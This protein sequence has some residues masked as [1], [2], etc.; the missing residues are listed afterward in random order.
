M[1]LNGKAKL[2]RIFVGESD[3]VKHTPLYEMIVKEAHA[4]GL[5]GA[6]AWRGMLSYGHT[7]HIHTAK[8]LDLSSNLPIVIEIIDVAT[9]IDGFIPRL[10]SLFEEAQSDGLVTAENVAIVKY[11]Q[12]AR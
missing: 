7:S 10:D 6:T 2:L 12:A 11:S 1:E 5:A 4:A 9:K 8:T 3:K